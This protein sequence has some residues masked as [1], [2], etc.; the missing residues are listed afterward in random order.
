MSQTDVTH[1]PNMCGTIPTVLHTYRFDTSKPA[2]AKA[3]AALCER[4]RRD[5]D[6]R[7]FNVLRD[8]G[9][10]Q[11]KPGPVAL[12]TDHVFADQWS[13]TDGRRV[14][15][16]YEGIVPNASIK[17]G[18]WLEITPA[19]REIRRNTLK[20]GFCG[21]QEPAAKGLEF[22]GACLD[23]PYLAETDLHLTRLLPAGEFMPDR[24]PLS[25]A[26]RD[27]LLP[28]YVARQTSGADSRNAAK[29]RKQRAGIEA[30]RGKAIAS[31]QTEADGLLWLMDRGISIDNVIFYDHTGVFCF[32]WRKPV[33]DA[34]A[35]TLLDQIS[36]F[37]HP[38][39]IKGVS[40][41][42]KGY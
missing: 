41:S 20:C 2:D 32:G 8:P 38:Y 37:P 16:W 25:D 6:R 33:S 27:R 18:H 14:F 21:H 29:L 42:W 13:T 40:R 12:E 31:A 5:K 1:D 36:E 28:L 22:C 39:E 23:S 15:D 4:L 17:I 34:V 9:A 7:F 24:A 30:K 35:S 3:Y 19:M 10:K 26:E 11:T